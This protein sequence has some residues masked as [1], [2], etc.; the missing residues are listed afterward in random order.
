MSGINSEG[1]RLK[2]QKYKGATVFNLQFLINYF[3]SEVDESSIFT[4]KIKEINL[5]K[6]HITY[7][8][9][10][11]EVKEYGMDYDHLD[12]W[13][14]SGKIIGLRNRGDVTTMN[15]EG[16]ALTDRSGFRLDNLSAHVLVNPRKIKLD[17]LIVKTPY[18]NI[19]TKGVRVEF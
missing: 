4:M 12:M 13:D 7:Y 16:L 8:D 15:V 14:V 19:V 1:A 6:T 18:S 2:I 9:W 3:A 11:K 5:N 10:N 17:K